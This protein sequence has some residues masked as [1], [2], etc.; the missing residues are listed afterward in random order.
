MM[1]VDVI[2]LTERYLS[3]LEEY[4]GNVPDDRLLAMIIHPFLATYGFKDR[5]VL[6]EEKGVALV[7]RVTQLLC[8]SMQKP[9][10][11]RSSMATK[12]NDGEGEGVSTNK[13]LS[14]KMTP[15]EPLLRSCEEGRRIKA[16]KTDP[17]ENA[18]NE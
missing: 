7:T 6:L 10:K 16:S 11:K 15:L 1:N 17:I 3:S 8:R 18:M 13:S 4:F 5:T 14:L 12:R 9:L 2:E